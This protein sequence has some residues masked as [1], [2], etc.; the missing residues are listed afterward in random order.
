MRELN[1]REFSP[2]TYY[3]VLCPDRYTQTVEQAL[4]CGGKG[5]LDLEVLTLSRLSRRII[6]TAK[7]L[8]QEGGIMITSRAISAVQKDLRY[9]ARAAEFS[10]FAR[11]VYMTIQ[12]IASSDI[13]IE[14][15]QATGSAKIKLDDIALIKRAYDN[16]K[17]E[18]V[19][20][21][22]RLFAI[23][24]NVN[25]D[26]ITKTN[27]YAIGYADTT[28][29][30][31]RVFSEIASHAQ[32]FVLFDAP[33][34]EDKR[35]SLD[36]FG[37]PDKISE[38]KHVAA[39][40]RD[41][42]YNGGRYE[43]VAV[44]ADDCRAMVRILSEYLIP[45]YTDESKPLYFTPPLSALDNFYR[46]YTAFK[47]RNAIDCDALIALAK[48]P[49]TGCD[50]FE[51]EMLLNDVSGKALTIVP[52]DYEF[53]AGEAAARRVLDGLKAFASSDF[54]E[55]VKSVLEH[56]K[57][58]D[59]ASAMG[60]TDA[61]T[62]I[63]N[64]VELLERYGSGDFDTDAKAFFSASRAVNVNTVPRERDCVT[65][66][67]PNTLRMTAVKKL[68]ITDFN[69]GVMPVAVADAGLI[70]DIEL[71]MM[72]GVVEPTVKQ[73]N[74]R[75]R[76]ELKAVV[77]NAGEAFV[78][79][80]SAGDAKPA[81]IISELADN[82]VQHE[83]DDEL[84][85]L[86]VTRDAETIAKH[87]STPAA[88]R[89]I[90]ARKLT[91][92][93]SSV[94]DATVKSSAVYAPFEDRISIKRKSTISVSEISSWF[95][96]PY[97]RFLQYSIGLSERKNGFGAPDFGT[98]IHEF[99]N[100][101]LE[102][103][104]Y[105]CS[106]AAVKKLLDDVLAEK[107]IKLE[108]AEYSRILGDAKDYAEENVRILNKGKYKVAAREYEFG[109]KNDKANRAV[110][111]GSNGRLRFEGK[112]DRFDVVDNRARIIDYKT[113]NK[114]FSIK[115]CADGTDMQLPLYAYA[116]PYNG[117]EPYDVT[118]MFYVRATGKYYT[119]RPD[120]SLSGQ[121][122]DDVD[123]VRE[124]DEDLYDEDVQSDVLSGCVKT[125]KEKGTYFS[126]RSNMPV[127]RSEMDE[128]I[129]QCKANADVAVDEICDGYILRSPIK[130]A[131]EY[132]PYCGI[133]GGGDV[134]ATGDDGTEGTEE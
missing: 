59:V 111:L 9:Y 55:A 114:T 14:D 78:S 65:V 109:K 49:Y 104:P 121:V 126:T 12:Q 88:A 19:D 91:L 112:I 36:L 123:I 35:A 127:K 16:I 70:S 116:M 11:E 80:C 32:K 75:S 132:C 52:R 18:Y 94:A 97:Y 41:Y 119:E 51:A 22:D 44:V 108:P 66:T 67:A 68:F 40:I 124:Y 24:N 74:K 102:A 34:R 122:I 46:L 28:K 110:L 10:D 73:R 84:V 17:G 62:P 81:A 63:L 27:F 15:I 8:S 101:L 131:C 60:G 82:I 54:G 98:V 29:L 107:K 90:V 20:S 87:A 6:P 106:D 133:C 5:A 4:F 45:T 92:S 93:A 37:A 128:L 25:R 56:Y 95:K 96:C 134:R 1:A 47:K 53:R 3:I 50:V 71:G 2:D 13:K 99:M 42:V 86:Y 61:V 83:Y 33:P 105:D 43:D 85:E 103:E 130:D 79:Y 118:G 100:K 26:L 129:L 117:E 113:G 57:F 31:N 23:I 72:G 125:S 89:E 115:E 69:E 64:L 39:Q 77:V 76:E 58:R 38:Y 21:P 30:I 7:T 48:N 120:K